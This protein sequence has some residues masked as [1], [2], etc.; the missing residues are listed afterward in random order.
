[1]KTPDNIA[2][3]TKIKEKKFGSTS[4]SFYQKIF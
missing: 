4:L 2:N 3:F 1:I